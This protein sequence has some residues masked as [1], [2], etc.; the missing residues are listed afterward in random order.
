MAVMV[1][2]VAESGDEVADVTRILGQKTFFGMWFL[3]M[4]NSRKKKVYDLHWSA[5]FIASY[6]CGIFVRVGSI[7]IGL[8]IHGKVVLGI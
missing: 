3:V 4:R 6:E 7:R 8:R 2:C 5:G 1:F